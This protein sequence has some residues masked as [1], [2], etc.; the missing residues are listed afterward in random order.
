MALLY[1]AGMTVPKPG[2]YMEVGSLNDRVP[3]AR[4][5]RFDL[6]GGK[7]PKPS[8]LRHRWVWVAPPNIKTIPY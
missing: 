4:H 7:F 3:C 5:I 2:V 6:A 1:K 8:S